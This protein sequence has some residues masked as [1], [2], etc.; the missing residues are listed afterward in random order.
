MGFRVWGLGSKL[1]PAGSSMSLHTPHRGRRAPTHPS[2]PHHTARK[3]NATA[4]K[5]LRTITSNVGKQSQKRAGGAGICDVAYPRRLWEGLST[6]ENGRR[7]QGKRSSGRHPNSPRKKGTRLRAQVRG[8][9]VGGE[10]W[11]GSKKGKVIC[12]CY[13]MFKYT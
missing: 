9:A 10:L 4:R 11:G 5:E 12:I 3:Q 6:F 8:N 1:S 7:G 2:I 13:L